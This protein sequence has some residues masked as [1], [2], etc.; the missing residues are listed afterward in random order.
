VRARKRTDPL[1]RFLPKV[2]VVAGGCWQWLGARGGSG[3]AYGVFGKGGRGNSGYAHRWSYEHFVGPIPDGYDIDHLCRNPTCV[4]PAHLEAV[5]HRENLR[6]GDTFAAA[7]AAKTHCKHGHEFTEE[8]TYITSSGSRSCRRCH[9]IWERGRRALRAASLAALVAAF[10]VPQ[11]TAHNVPNSVHNRVHA[12]HWAFCGKQTKTTC[13]LG[14]Q[15]VRVAKCESGWSMTPR[16][17]NGQ[18]L[19]MFQMGS[20]ARGRYGHSSNPWGQ[21]RAAA[22]YY[23]D[24][25]WSPWACRP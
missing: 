5:P 2:V 7:N 10:A 25:G 8:N 6:R 4:N 14:W 22:R 16:A 3:S 18:Y 24:A 9:A 19:G 17:Q 13:G 12:V 21:A 1:A 20:F 11:A 15:A 23:R